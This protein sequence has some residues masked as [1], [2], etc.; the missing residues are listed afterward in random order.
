MDRRL[1]NNMADFL[2]ISQHCK[3]ASLYFIQLS[4]SIT[5]PNILR[6]SGTY[7]ARL[8]YTRELLGDLIITSH[9]LAV[10][11]DNYGYRMLSSTIYFVIQE[12]IILVVV[13]VCTFVDRFLSS[14]VN[15]H[16]VTNCYE[17]SN[18]RTALESSRRPI[19][20]KDWSGCENANASALIKNKNKRSLNTQAHHYQQASI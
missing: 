18:T 9:N 11:C 20:L 8:W 1:L 2:L 13:A 10:L 4:P 5:R 17:Y 6:Q 16:A 15:S 3:T 14:E 12:R 19:V 7:I